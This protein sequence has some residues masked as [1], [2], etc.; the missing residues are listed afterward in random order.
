MILRR[1]SLAVLLCSALAPGIAR[2][3]EVSEGDKAAA[4][5]LVVEGFAALERK[6]YATAAD[7]FSRADT[8]VHAPTVS[9]GLARA[10]VGLG[11][12]VSAQENYNRVIHE[13]LLPGASPAF[14]K[15]VE[16]GRTE[17]AALAPRVPSLVIQVRGAGVP[18]VTLDGVVVPPALLGAKRP[19]NP[20]KH[21]IRAV[22]PTLETR[23]ASVTVGEGQTETVTLNLVGAPVGAPVAEVVAPGPGPAPV[24]VPVADTGG[25][26]G[27]GRRPIGFALLGVGAAGLAV[28]A[29][30]RSGSRGAST[31]ASSS[32]ARPGTARRA[33]RRC[34]SRTSTATARSGASRWAG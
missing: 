17:L 34:S 9:L 23:E 10:Q 29:I 7:R 25:G 22:A 16:D 24:P 20:G 11:K 8:V 32:S 12:F 30:P 15:A 4:R 27:S 5:Q 18:K 13:G 1:F 3:Q 26:A 21:L 33:S 31:R 2:A 19:V 28:G 14:V 6:D